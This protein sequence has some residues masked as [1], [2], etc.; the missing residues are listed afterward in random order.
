[1]YM[2]VFQVYFNPLLTHTHTH[3]HTLAHTSLAVSLCVQS[4]GSSLNQDHLE[5]KFTDYIQNEVRHHPLVCLSVSLSLSLSP[6][7]S[8]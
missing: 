6:L 7:L 2:F 8:L 1:M 3:T 4:V 5:S